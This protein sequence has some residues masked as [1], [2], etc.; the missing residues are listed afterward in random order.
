M[1]PVGK[2]KHAPR[3][4]DPGMVVHELDESLQCAVL[5]KRVGVEEEHVLRRA[6]RRERSPDDDVVPPGES[7]VGMDQG[8]VHP[9]A[10]PVG[11]DLSSEPL[12]GVAPRSVLANGYAGAWDAPD[13]A[14]QGF[15]AVQG[16]VGDV[17]VEDDDEELHRATHPEDT[18]P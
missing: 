6:G 5:H 3:N 12:A 18:C 7:T 9:G 8:E 14:G 15:Q 10:P 17:V 2:E 4:P 13:P 16:Q 11:V 1:A